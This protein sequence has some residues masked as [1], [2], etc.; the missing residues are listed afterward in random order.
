MVGKT[1]AQYM[2][3]LSE[4]EKCQKDNVPQKEM[5]KADLK[6]KKAQDEYK[7]WREKYQISTEDYIIHMTESCQVRRHITT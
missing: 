1:K 2:K 3:F 4:V 6:M 5:E 7:A